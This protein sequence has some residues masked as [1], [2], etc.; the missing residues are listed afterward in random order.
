MISKFQDG[1]VINRKCIQSIDVC[2]IDDNGAGEKVKMVTVEDPVINFD[3]FKTLFCNHEL[4]ITEEALKSVDC[5]LE[6]DNGQIYLIEF[7][8]GKID[9]S[10]RK[11]LNTKLKDS[12]LMINHSF[13]Q[14]LGYAKTNINYV[15][16]YNSTKNGLSAKSFKSAMNKKTSKSKSIRFDLSKMSDILNSVNTIAQE[17]FNQFW[18]D[19][20]SK[21]LLNPTNNSYCA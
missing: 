2:S 21:R 10:V 19:K 8:N 6:L 1:K 3:R 9:N 18:Q 12:L 20:I 5:Y 7:K 11:D 13:E 17:D 4:G 16:V 15:V 14:N